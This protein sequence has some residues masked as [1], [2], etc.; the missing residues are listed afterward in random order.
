MMEKKNLWSKFSGAENSFLI[1]WDPF[2]QRKELSAFVKK[3]CSPLQ[4][5]NVDGILGLEKM[6]SSEFRWHFYNADGSEAEMCGNA[7]RCATRF[8]LDQVAPVAEVTIWTKNGAV[9]GRRYKDRQIE[10]KFQTPIRQVQIQGNAAVWSGVPHLL[11][12]ASEDEFNSEPGRQALR[13]KATQMRLLNPFPET[14]GTNVTFFA[15]LDSSLDFFAVTFERGVED[16]TRACGTG[17]IAVAHQACEGR[18]GV[19]KVKMPGGWLEV[20]FKEGY[21]YLRGDATRYF[22]VELQ[23]EM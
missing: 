9:F 15:K 7:A 18:P 22:S 11:L 16:F 17:A 3:M 10:V 6:N 4:G 1:S 21:T 19:V 14:R 12:S 20:E 8:L 5:F 23:S 2:W 13:R